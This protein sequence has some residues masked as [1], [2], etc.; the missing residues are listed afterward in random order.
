MRI[1][2]FCIIG[3]IL[4]ELGYFKLLRR[5][6]DDKTVNA[7]EKYFRASYDDIM[8]ISFEIMVWTALLIAEYSRGLWGLF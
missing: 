8:V 6:T 2:N 5:A 1:A 4:K 7:L 3:M